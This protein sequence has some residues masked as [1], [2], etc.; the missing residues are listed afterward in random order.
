MIVP[1]WKSAS[2]WQELHADDGFLKWFIAECRL[3][4]TRNAI[5]KGRGNNGIFGKPLRFRMVAL[6]VRF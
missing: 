3:L 6:E 2:Y 1:L 5:C 4:P